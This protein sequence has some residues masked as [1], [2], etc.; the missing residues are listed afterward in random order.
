MY[1]TRYRSLRVSNKTINDKQDQGLI[2]AG[3]GYEARGVSM[4]L[5]RGSSGKVSRMEDG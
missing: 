3:C 2:P 4:G 1:S 5:R